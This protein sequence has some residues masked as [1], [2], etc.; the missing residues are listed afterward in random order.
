MQSMR[1][2]GWQ[3]RYCQ[4][5]DGI[6]AYGLYVPRRLPRL[7]RAPVLVV[8]HGCTQSAEDIAAGTRMNTLA[9]RRGVVAVYP[10]QGERDN[11]N[12]CWNWYDPGHQSRGSGEPAAI[13]GIVREVFSSDLG[14][15]LDGNRVYVVG[16]SAGAAM[17]VVMGATYPD[18]F[19]AVGA[20]SG[21]SYAAARSAPGALLSMRSG[22]RDPEA[23][24]RQAWLAMGDRAVTMPV[25]IVQG[26]ADATVWRVNGA[27]VAQQW[28]ATNRRALGGSV[29]LDPGRPDQVV[30]GRP[31]D[32]HSYEMR[33]WED[34]SG[35]PIVQLCSVAGLGHA[36]SGGSPAGSYTDTTGPNA[37]AMMWAFLR[38]QSRAVPVS[39]VARLRHV[40]E[41]VRR[42]RHL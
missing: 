18:L 37:T 8:L 42:R 15:R 17:A 14:A 30:R 9:E 34:G 31:H 10:E 24:G 35:R 21:L 29:P 11:R 20:H 22:G 33:T 23:C 7:S 13:A 5:D 26:D 4:A 27:Q 41:R 25:V 6:R 1:V 40:L 38:Q 2:A 16:M 19:A 28:L 3:R 36:W 32:G 12:R 39:R